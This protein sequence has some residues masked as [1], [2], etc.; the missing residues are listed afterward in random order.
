MVR[1][2]GTKDEKRSN[3]VTIASKFLDWPVRSVNFFF[4]FYLK[5]IIYV[6][7]LLN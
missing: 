3:W 4:F 1:G 6:W 2:L 5:S 7:F